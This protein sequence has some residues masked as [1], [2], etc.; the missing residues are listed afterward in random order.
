MNHGDSVGEA[1]SFRLNRAAHVV[2]AEANAKA[3]TYGV[4][5]V[6][7]SSSGTFGG[8]ARGSYRVTGSIL[9]VTVDANNTGYPGFLLWRAF[10]ASFLK[11]NGDA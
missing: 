3:S 7:N 5:I 8:T 2:L 6:G 10:G 11:G 1:R 4:S 9:D